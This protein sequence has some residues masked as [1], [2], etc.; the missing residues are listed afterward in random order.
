MS[1]V[2]FLWK[3]LTLCFAWFWCA[4][5][6]DPQGFR[7]YLFRPQKSTICPF[8]PCKT[9]NRT[10]QDAKR[11]RFKALQFSAVSSPHRSAGE[12]RFKEKDGAAE[13][14]PPYRSDIDCRKPT[15]RVRPL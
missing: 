9:S 11:A 15:L 12:S 4:A 13:A 2:I 3:I 1:Y 10:F 5:D 14:A 6:P 7:S 8:A